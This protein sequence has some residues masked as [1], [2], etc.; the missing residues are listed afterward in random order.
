MK[1]VMKYL[2]L[3][4]ICTILNVN[5]TFAEEACSYKTKAELN[6][7][8]V[9]VTSSYE[10][11]KDANNKE[12]FEITLGN[13]VENL[14]LIIEPSS[15]T[16][17]EGSELATIEIYNSLT[18][19]GTYT[20]KVENLTD[21]ITYKIRIRSTIEGCTHDVFTTSLVKPRKNKFYSMQECKYEEVIDYLY[22][23][24]WVE[25]EFTLTDSEVLK[26]IQNQRGA[27]KKTIT[28]KC[29]QCEADVRNDAKR[30]K[31]KLIKLYIIIG[32]VIGIIADI[33][34]IVVLIIRV[35]RSEI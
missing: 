11:K 13:I 23:Q 22:C 3:S 15:K 19:D 16:L 24:E 20:F 4:I 18:K 34:T 8:A 26:R 14:Y 31:Y 6:K 12:Y 32:L 29:L 27:N 28:T 33:I 2:F 25:T 30:N 9:Q 17:K 7:L 5:N 21:V 35:R 1:R 10:I